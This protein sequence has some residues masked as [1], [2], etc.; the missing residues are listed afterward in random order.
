MVISHDM[1]LINNSKDRTINIKDGKLNSDTNAKE[2]TKPIAKK[3]STTKE[4]RSIELSKE[5][6]SLSKSLKEKLKK[7]AIKSPDILLNITNSEL[8]DMKLSSKE[9]KELGEFVKK[10]LNTN[11]NE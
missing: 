2:I 10:Y 1:N 3:E 4:K 6:E 8:K 9:N 7:F 5:F 11:K